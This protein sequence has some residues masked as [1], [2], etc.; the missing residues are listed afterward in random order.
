MALGFSE[1]I[2]RESDRTVYQTTYN[3][4][5]MSFKQSYTKHTDGLK[6]QIGTIDVYFESE[7]IAQIKWFAHYDRGGHQTKQDFT[8]KY[9][10]VKHGI[11]K[12][13]NLPDLMIAHAQVLKV[14][15]AVWATNVGILGCQDLSNKMA[16]AIRMY[17]SFYGDI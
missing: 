16:D 14:F 2:I 17:G 6:E 15:N 12:V 10:E 7:K 3:G 13:H 5:C 1:N 4:F 9:F 8:N 11:G